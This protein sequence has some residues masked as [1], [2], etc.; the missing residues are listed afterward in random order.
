MRAQD[1]RLGDAFAGLRPTSRSA[2][3][4]G[5]PSRPAWHLHPSP[6][7]VVIPGSGQPETVRA[8][9]AAADTTLTPEDP[10][11]P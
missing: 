10:A 2:P 11:R 6:N 5:A 3:T 1:T 7:V 8:S 9:A 4:P